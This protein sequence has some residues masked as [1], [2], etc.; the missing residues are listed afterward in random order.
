MD[1]KKLN[2]IHAPE[3]WIE[4]VY[5]T[6]QDME[7]RNISGKISGKNRY[8]TRRVAV[9]AGFVICCIAT[10][11]VAAVASSDFRMWLRGQFALE[12]TATGQAGEDAAG[13][14]ENHETQAGKNE[15]PKI[16]RISLPGD[17]DCIDEVENGF[18]MMN[19]ETEDEK[20]YAVSDGELKL[21]DLKHIQ[22]NIEFHG[23][24]YGYSFDYALQGRRIRA[25]N[26]EG[27][28]MF[29]S[30]QMPEDNTAIVWFEME[31]LWNS[32]YLNLD[33]GEVVSVVDDGQI[34]AL[35]AKKYPW[36]EVS[37]DGDEEVNI[38]RE[39]FVKYAV[40]VQMSPEGT[41]LLYASNRD[42]LPTDDSQ[43][44]DP[45]QKEWFVK[46]RKTGEEK[47]LEGVSGYLHQNEIGFIDDTHIAIAYMLD[48]GAPAVY[49]C[50]TNHLEV[51]APVD[52]SNY[53]NSLIYEMG[54]D[55]QG[56]VFYDLWTN[57]NY[58]IALNEEEWDEYEYFVVD[59]NLI[60]FGGSSKAFLVK[61]KKLLDWSSE[62]FS[63]V[64]YITEMVNLEDDRYLFFGEKSG[65][66]I[67]YLLEL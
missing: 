12:D 17:T 58:K 42:N 54:A 44:Y 60:F 50:E 25:Q 34:E 10:F 64:D 40:D 53:G 18:L 55:E 48:D 61:E 15:E 2:E 37:M 63:D 20:I 7:K 45:D 11:S 65:E 13:I 23:K 31:N 46:N 28:A 6:V 9:A 49:D 67:G 62:G 19:G 51:Y 66:H 4:E 27:A 33:T 16:T 35:T 1:I 8:N 21:C 5:S 26:F 32:Y 30:G 36:T 22:G 52:G 41:Y 43:E 39:G 29:V 14:N 57:E 3:E 47:K 24:S 56:I 59:R 38:P